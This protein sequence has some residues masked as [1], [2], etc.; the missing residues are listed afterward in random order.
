M[1]TLRRERRSPKASETP[2]HSIS[3]GQIA[4]SETEKV[5]A[6]LD[7]HFSESSLP[8]VQDMLG[9]LV[10]NAAQ[11][12]INM[13]RDGYPLPP[14]G[15]AAILLAPL[16]FTS[17]ASAFSLASQGQLQPATILTRSLHEDVALGILLMGSADD[18]TQ[19][20]SG[21][22]YS[23]GLV[24]QRSQT[25]SSLSEAYNQLSALAHPNRAAAALYAFSGDAC[26]YLAY[27]GTYAPKTALAIGHL[28]A[29]IQHR[30][31]CAFYSNFGTLLASEGAFLTKGARDLG[32]TED[33]WKYLSAVLNTYESV[34]NDVSARIES[35]KPDDLDGRARVSVP[36]LS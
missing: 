4:R 32:P 13:K 24:R 28:V 10:C 22:V 31:I 34:L 5:T 9:G 6:R 29:L 25:A 17:A 11:K 16:V 36:G 3:V 26:Q 33:H 14:Q 20:F 30:F 18:A 7:T 27:G 8:M 2:A 12:L 21:K 15:E 23:Q 1:W 19:W 35:M